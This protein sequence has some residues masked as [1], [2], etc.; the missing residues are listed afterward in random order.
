MA[1]SAQVVF[2]LTELAEMLVKK[3]NLHEGHWGILV[4]FGVG[5][6]NL[7]DANGTLHPTIVV[8]IQTIGIQRFELPNSL[9]VDA[10]VVNPARGRAKSSRQSI[11]QK[12][13]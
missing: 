2:K 3:E 13:K 6:G 1:E 8:P 4:N 7:E 10:S 11:H 5:G 12:A 9:T